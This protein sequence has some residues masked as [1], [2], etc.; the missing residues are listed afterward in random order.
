MSLQHRSD[1]RRPF[2]AIH[3][4]Q[5]RP[6]PTSELRDNAD[7]FG[8]VVEEL[9]VPGVR[10][11]RDSQ[12]PVFFIGVVFMDQASVINDFDRRG[13]GDRRRGPVISPKDDRLNPDESVPS[14]DQSFIPVGGVS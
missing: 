13:F 7:A 8:N 1:H 5:S 11:G 4:F 12:R 3:H 6:P 14:R 2:L 9:F 10:G